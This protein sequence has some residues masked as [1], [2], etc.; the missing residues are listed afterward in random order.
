MFRRYMSAANYAR[1]SR[2]LFPEQFMT[3]TQ[4]K[5]Y[6]ADLMI[7]GGAIGLSY[8][9]WKATNRDDVIPY[10]ALGTIIGIG[11]GLCFPYSAPAFG[12]I[13]AREDY[14]HRRQCRVE[15][16]LK[17]QANEAELQRL[18]KEVLQR[19]QT[20]PSDIRRL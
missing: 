1:V 9:I 10:A 6:H 8:G 15:Q 12:M 13:A 18:R 3:K 19:V 14:L 5:A 11:A 2:F 4:K 17:A 20:P 16:E 7:G